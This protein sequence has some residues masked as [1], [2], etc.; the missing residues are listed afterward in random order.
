MLR[1]LLVCVAVAGCGAGG[2]TSPSPATPPGVAT[3]PEAEVYE[4]T[5]TF[6]NTD[7][8]SLFDRQYFAYDFDLATQVATPLYAAHPNYGT[9][10]KAK[11]GELLYENDVPDLV[12]RAPGKPAA[13][14]V[15]GGYVSLAAEGVMRDD[16]TLIAFTRRVY[17]GIGADRLRVEVV[18]RDRNLRAT[19]DD[20]YTAAWGPDGRLVVA[21]ERA[22]RVVEPSLE[23]PPRQIGPDISNPATPSVSPDGR[24]VAF[25][26]DGQI[27]TMGLD[28]TDLK[29]ITTSGN[30]LTWP[31]WS[32]DGR[33]LVANLN[34]GLYENRVVILPSSPSAP[35]EVDASR[36]VRVR[37]GGA[38]FMLEARSRITWR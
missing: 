6:Q 2:E 36:M 7:D 14:F 34:A 18:D 20:V 29:Q 5:L 27:F 35:V 22:L 24:R 25:A 11:N 1:L 30:R 33:H 17:S 19:F 8:A 32:P 9:V 21:S 3:E 23:G 28:G 12:V 15:P 37:R 31:A 13:F 16:G 38:T 10:F 26:S 4:G